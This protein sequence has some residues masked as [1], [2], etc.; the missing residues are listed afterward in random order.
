M[1]LGENHCSF[2][3]QFFADQIGNPEAVLYPKRDRA[4]K[5]GEAARRVSQISLENPLKFKKRLFVKGDEIEIAGG[6]AGFPKAEID[7][8]LRKL[9]IVLLP[10]K[11]LFLRRRDDFTVPHETGS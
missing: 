1:M 11:A 5:R 10:R 8:A 9:E 4:E 7:R 2:V 6:E 3:I